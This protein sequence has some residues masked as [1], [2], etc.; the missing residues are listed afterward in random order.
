MNPARGDTKLVS[1]NNS[2]TPNGV[3]VLLFIIPGV[4]LRFTPG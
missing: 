2:A 4:P 1:F 3:R